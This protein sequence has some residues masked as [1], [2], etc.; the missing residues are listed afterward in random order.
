MG[1]AARQ[2]TAGGQREPDGELAGIGQDYPGWQPWRSSAGRWWAVRQGRTWAPPDV[3]VAWAR[4]VDGDTAEQ[5]RAA[6]DI[7]AGLGAPG[8]T[9]EGAP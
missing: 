9:G 4:T 2:G 6:L 1:R 7:Q 5:L 8:R 3:P